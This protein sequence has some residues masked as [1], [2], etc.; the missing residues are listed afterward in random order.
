MSGFD[1]VATD[2]IA[3]EFSDL[4]SLYFNTA[5]MGPS[6]KRAVDVGKSF[7]A[8]EG[9]PSFLPYE[10]WR[11]IPNEIRAK[12][13]KLL[14]GDPQQVSIHTATG[15]F[16]SLIA[17]GFPW[18]ASDVVVGFQ[19]EY[20]SNVLPWLV[21]EKS[22]PYSLKLLDGE[23]RFDIEALAKALPA[24]TRLLN[25]SHVAFDSGKRVDL[26]ALGKLTRERGIFLV[27]DSSQALGGIAI[28]E[29]ELS[30]IDVYGGCTY[31]WLLGPYGNAYAYWKKEAIELVRPTVV[32]W[33]SSPNSDSADDLL[34]Y[35]DRCKPGAQRFDRGQAPNVLPMKIL[36]AGLDYLAELGLGAIEKHNLGLFNYFCELLPRERFSLLTPTDWHATIVFVAS[37]KH[38]AAEL[39][40]RL[41]DNR[42]D[43]S[44]REGQLRL[45]F[46]FFNTKEQVDKLLELLD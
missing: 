43:A 28:S 31:K 27:V 4:S 24:K 7:L 9:D 30:N 29:E 36:G 26:R 22:Q 25:L 44:V 45:S 19:G 3:K 35:T 23:L 15:E 33:L 39:Q 6:P 2:K 11:D 13:A 46:N 41:A 37:K 16:N 12:I 20:P 14:A 1:Q 8:Q 42:V 21:N 5:Y 17:L 32:S 40:R 38:D 18:Q 34:K 10:K